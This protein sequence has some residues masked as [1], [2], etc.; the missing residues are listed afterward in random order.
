MNLQKGAGIHLDS[1]EIPSNLHRLIPVVERWAFRKQSDQDRF[2]AEMRNRAP[3]EVREFN[4]LIDSSREE[5]VNW[6]ESLDWLKKNP[7][8]LTTEDLNHPY[9]AFLDVLRIRDLTGVDFEDPEVI[10]AKERLT[11]EI[12]D[13]KYKSA[14]LQAD[15]AFR[16]RRYQ[17]YVRI[18]TPFQ[19]RLTEAQKLKLKKAQ[20]Q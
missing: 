12:E 15:A 18:V 8:D 3:A 4:R 20:K 2:V 10:A 11:M 1:A 9:R 6:G 19:D 17:E 5:I 14:S 13:D 7:G 16:E